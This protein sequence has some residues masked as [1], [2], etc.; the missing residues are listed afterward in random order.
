ML[1]RQV[2]SKHNTMIFINTHL[3]Y[4]IRCYIWTVV[5][6]LSFLFNLCMFSGKRLSGKV[7]NGKRVIRETSFRESDYLGNILKPL[8]LFLFVLFFFVFLDPRYYYYYYSYFLSGLQSP[9]QPK[10]VIVFRPVT[11]YTA[12][13]QM[14]IGVNNLRKDVTQLCLYGNWTHDLLITGPTPYHYA[15]APPRWTQINS[16]RLS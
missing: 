11:S 8:L 7:T 1:K 12:W 9:S 15:T 2:Y 6:L 10:S 16:M 3:I 4:Q 5:S 13:W 14:H